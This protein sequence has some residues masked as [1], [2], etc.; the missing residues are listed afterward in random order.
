MSLS[1]LQVASSFPA[2]GGAELHILNLSDQLQRRGHDVT[3]ACRP[4]CWVEER[5]K[6]LGLPTLPIIVK[7]QGDWKDFSSL[8]R[9]IRERQM[10]V[11][12]VHW[13]RDMMVSGLAGRLEHVPVRIMTRHMP[14]PFKS[15]LGT[16]LY[17]RYF[18]TRIVAISNS[19]R[20]T[21]RQCG[22]ANEKIEVIHHGTDIEAFSQTTIERKI[23]RRDLGIPDDCV[24]VGIV[25]RIAPEKGHNVILEAFGRL[26]DRYPL[27]LVVAGSGPDE[28][29]IRE[30]IEKLGLNEKVIFTG[31][32]D[33]V[34]NIIAALDIV[35][36]PSTWNEPCSAV[37]Q[38]GMALSKPV[39][40]TLTGGSPE[41]ILDGETG[42]L[43]PPSDS[44]ALAG[45]VETLARDAFLRRRLGAA[46][47][48]RVVSHFSLQIM[49]DKIEALYQREY[50]NARGAGALEK[51]LASYTGRR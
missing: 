28:M 46:G 14:Y 29:L 51:S 43:V 34:N 6:Q 1:V 9:F 33:D 44:D 3:V 19:V 23:V 32:R 24:A 2:W 45:A 50:E 11:V 21:L 7:W 18:F 35:T 38:Q 42:L 27:K 5:A 37:I 20:E 22:V 16:A 12:H 25:G 4:G 40:G 48:E 39:I 26:G 17:S 41:M 15:R 10:Q 13:S 8:R 36:V 31:F 49:T 47:R 30:K